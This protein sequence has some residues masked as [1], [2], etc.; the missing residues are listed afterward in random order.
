MSNNKNNEQPVDWTAEKFRLARHLFIEE[1]ASADRKW[2]PDNRIWEWEQFVKAASEE[3]II[4]AGTFINTCMK[5]LSGKG[6]GND[7]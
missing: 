4:A 7:G 3:A 5:Y 2:Y 1:L 6:G